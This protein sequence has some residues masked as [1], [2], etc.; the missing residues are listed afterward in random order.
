MPKV[1]I[2]TLDRELRSGS[3]RPVYAIIGEELY[4]SQSALRML[5]DKVVGDKA[6][7][8]F[9]LRTFSA[10]E[11]SPADILDATRTV[12]FLSANILVIIRDAEKLKKE[13]QDAIVEYL[14]SPSA[15]T[16]LVLAGTKID[17]RSKCMQSI[18]KVGAVVECKPLY[19]NKIP[20][21]INMETKR[22]DKQM[23]QQAA[24]FLADMVGNDLGQLIQAIERLVLY[25]GDK[26][27]IDLSDVEESIA[28]THQRTIFELA[29]AV[30]GRKLEKAISLLHNILENGMAPVLALN[31]LARHF[32]ILSK[33]KEITGR[34]DDK[35]QIAKYLGVHPFY[36]GNYMSQSRNFSGGELRLAFRKLH[37]CDRS[38]KSSRIPKERV[39]EKALFS[40]IQK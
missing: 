3:I 37:N 12:P 19:A 35:A 9:G 39:L 18:L 33:A 8:D 36:A 11:A 34:M 2:T 10:K 24:S 14:E 4:L 31:M 6:N 15:T 1:D 38:L 28:E 30:G 17:G 40:I 27:L 5:K 32:R 21:W 29:D 25:V 23:S 16:V 20:S 22:K 26:K 13:I 7:E